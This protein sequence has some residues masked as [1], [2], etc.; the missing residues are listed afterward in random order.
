MNLRKNILFLAILVSTLL[1][2]AAFFFLPGLFT[3]SWLLFSLWGIVYLSL[4][5]SAVDVNQWHSF[6]NITRLS[7]ALLISFTLTIALFMLGFSGSKFFWKDPGNNSRHHFLVQEGFISSGSN[8]IYIAGNIYQDVQ[9][10]LEGEIALT[11]SGSQFS[12]SCKQIPY[13]VYVS[14]Q[15]DRNIWQLQQTGLPA[16]S[17]L[18]TLRVR[19]NETGE[20]EEI[21]IQTQPKDKNKFE[22]LINYKGVTD[23]LEDKTIAYGVRFSDL[24]EN[25]TL[26]LSYD[27]IQSLQ[28]LYLLKTTIQFISAKNYDSPVCWYY[29]KDPTY[30]YWQTKLVLPQ[31]STLELTSSQ[32]NYDLLSLQYFNK[33]ILLEDKDR[34]YFGYEPAAGKQFLQQP[35]FSVEQT[36]LDKFS[37]KYLQPQIFPLPDTKGRNHE[38]FITSHNRLALQ[39]AGYAGYILPALN[40]ENTDSN[41]N[42]FWADLQYTTGEAG[43]PVTGAR[44]RLGELQLVQADSSFIASPSST[45]TG[46]LL[47]LHNSWVSVGQ[48]VMN[49]LLPL[50]LV[51]FASLAFIYIYAKRF[52]DQKNSGTPVFF[53][54]LLNI[55]LYFFLLRLL[56]SWRV[57]SYPYTDAITK[58]EY[59]DFIEKSYLKTSVLGISISTNLLIGVLICLALGTFLVYQ[60]LKPS[61]K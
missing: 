58:N 9:A 37:L 23:T 47:K 1:S 17:G 46:W 2:G 25:T 42:H 24:L 45:S 57:R 35:A 55:I 40:F 28:R 19:L 50:L 61:K 54:W 34:F 32:G 36:G 21:K 52:S 22:F 26:P 53:W 7:V 8:P 51:A 15:T 29:G 43:T 39:H 13:P 48:D 56:L 4:G 31:L 44:F 6:K 41:Y 3:G 27:M 59:N 14:K 60:F 18:Q 30:Q 16:V 20:A 33:T 38:V 5:F 10:G 11:Q 12:L 49:T